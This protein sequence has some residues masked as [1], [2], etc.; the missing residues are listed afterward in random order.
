LLGVGEGGRSAVEVVACVIVGFVVRLR[1]CLQYLG[2]AEEEGEGEEAHKENIQ[3]RRNLF[4]E[5]KK[6]HIWP[7][8]AG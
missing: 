3:L 2:D 5:R 1:F 8:R 7:G 4:Q 6:M